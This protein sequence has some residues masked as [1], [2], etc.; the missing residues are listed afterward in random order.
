MKIEPQNKDTYIHSLG[1]F[2]KTHT[3][4]HGRTSPMFTFKE[5]HK[6]ENTW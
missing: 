2:V 1:C 5:T 4:T 6:K 3:H